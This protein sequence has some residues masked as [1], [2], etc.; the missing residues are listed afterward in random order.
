MN[1][2]IRDYENFLA[3]CSSRTLTEAAARQSMSQP[4]MSESISRLEE[5]LSGKLFYRTRAGLRLTAKGRIYRHKIE[6]I[7]HLLRDL[8]ESQK[9]RISLTI[10]CHRSIG[11]YALPL[12]LRSLAQQIDFTCSLVHDRSRSIQHQVQN[13]LIDIGLV[14]NPTPTPDLI[15]TGIGVDIMRVYGDP[16]SGNLICDPELVQTSKILRR[17]SP[18]ASKI[19]HSDSF[20]VMASLV[21]AGIGWAI[22]PERIA[23]VFM[24][25]VVALPGTPHHRDRL[26]VLYRPELRDLGI[27]AAVEELKRVLVSQ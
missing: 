5:Q 14:M 25:E 15:I 24:P 21:R 27:R 11:I 8:N 10:G 17:L 26:A 16:S 3:A 7:T 4:A 13:G 22:L 9:M 12:F 18:K 1:Y 19:I 23:R 2:R 6:E 20:E